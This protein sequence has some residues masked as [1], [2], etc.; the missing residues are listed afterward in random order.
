MTQTEGC[1]KWHWQDN[2]VYHLIR[3]ILFKMMF[4]INNAMRKKVYIE[5]SIPSFYYEDRSDAPAAARREWTRQWW[6]NNRDAYELLS[7]KRRVGR[8]FAATHIF[9]I[10]SYLFLLMGWLW[11]VQRSSTHPTFYFLCASAFNCL[12]RPLHVGLSLYKN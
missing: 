2:P 11:W 4:W 3:A 8:S 6:D 7:S 5:T 9:P 10:I 1:S 12:N